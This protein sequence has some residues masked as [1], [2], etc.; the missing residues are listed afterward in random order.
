MTDSLREYLKDVLAM[1]IIILILYY[2]FLAGQHYAIL[3]YNLR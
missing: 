3:T 1:V 2:V